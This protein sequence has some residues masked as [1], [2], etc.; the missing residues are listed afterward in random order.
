M[1][2]RELAGIAQEFTFWKEFIQTDQFCRGWLSAAPSPELLPSVRDFML[3][4]PEARVLDVG[5]GVVS[6]LHGT[7]PQDR[8]T[9]VDPLA[10]LYATIFDYQAHGIEPPV[11]QPAEELDLR[12][13]LY[14]IVHMR[15]ALD[16]SQDPAA[17]LDRLRMHTRRGRDGWIIIQGFEL[18]G[19]RQRWEGFHQ[20]NLSADNRGRLWAYD[21]AGTGW[22]LGEGGETTVTDLPAGRWFIWR[23]RYR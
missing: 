23:Q 9:A 21:Q 10:G 12:G 2:E 5:S 6:V 22:I 3:E 11:A 17:A 7:V 14:E 18:E 13:R 8:L 1:T 15:N 16:H 20:W 4:R 19:S